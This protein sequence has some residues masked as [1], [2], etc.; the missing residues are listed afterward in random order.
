V[1]APR[2]SA[3]RSTFERGCNI[4]VGTQRGRCEVPR[5]SLLVP[6]GCEHLR[7]DSVRRASLR[8][9]RRVIHRPAH[10]RVSEEDPV[11]AQNDQSCVLSRLQHR[12]NDADAAESRDDRLEL[13]AITR[14]YEK[15]RPSRSFAKRGSA[16]GE[17]TLDGR[18]ELQWLLERLAPRQLSG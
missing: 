12:T 13:V 7:Q 16:L 3:R 1:R 10:E 11:G 8:W 9:R 5:P 18:A 15:Q 14:R 6:R 2:L 17:G 4:L